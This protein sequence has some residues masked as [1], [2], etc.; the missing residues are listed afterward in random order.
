MA[1]LFQ[2]HE[3]IHFHCLGLADP[4]D[5][6]PRKIDKHNVLRTILFGVE[7]LSAQLLVLYGRYEMCEKK[8]KVSRTDL[9][10]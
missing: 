8:H 5:V 4:V 2:A 9:L 6:V 3:M 1:K 7:Q 10:V